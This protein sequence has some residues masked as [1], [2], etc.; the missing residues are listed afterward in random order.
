VVDFRISSGLPG[1]VFPISI[2]LLIIRWSASGIQLPNS[3]KCVLFQKIYE[4]F[5]G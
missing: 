4:L 5:F 1:T 3:P 2:I